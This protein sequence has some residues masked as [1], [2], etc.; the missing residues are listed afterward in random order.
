[1]AG[2]EQKILAAMEACRTRI[3]VAEALARDK[4]AQHV[5]ANFT[6]WAGVGT[7]AIGPFSYAGL[8]AIGLIAAAGGWAWKTSID[9]ALARA[10]KV[11]DIESKNLTHLQSDLE[12]E[13]S[14][15]DD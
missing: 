1:M 3:A 4:S 6:L 5:Q 13:R 10:A 9:E 12:F 11:A 7:A 14:I 2:E 15:D 8:T